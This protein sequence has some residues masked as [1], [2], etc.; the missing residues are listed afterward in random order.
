MPTAVLPEVESDTV[1]DKTR[2][3]LR[4]DEISEVQ[5]LLAEIA[6]RYETTEDPDFQEEAPL[7]AHELPVRIRREMLHFKLYEP[8]SALLVVGGYPIDEEKIGPTPA[9]W[10]LQELRRRVHEEEIF[11]VLLA[12]LLGECIG[13]STQQDGHLVHDIVPIAAHR[14][15]QLGSG[16]DTEL[17]WHIEDAFH[18]FRGDYL[19]LACLRNPDRVP[20]TF[21]TLEGIELPEEQMALLFEPHFTIRPD[22]SHKKKNKSESRQ[23]D[24]ELEH[25]YEEI[26]RMD[27]RPDKIAVLFGD[28]RAPYLRIDPYFMDPVE[29]PAAQAALDALIA[30]IGDKIED[31]VLQPG[32]F[33]FVDNFLGVHGRKPFKARFDGTDRWMK[34]V[35]IVRDLRKSRTARRSPQSRLVG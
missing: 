14:D 2:V 8:P 30:A 23:V 27:T 21:A 4:K 29:D 35:N 17:T 19:G 5:K 15:E 32:D 9:H 1:E 3:Q 7:L 22:E 26:E 11:Q 24:D 25:S 34:R 31:L 10:K 33:C 20:T 18:P 28:P 13:W 16:S 6:G 12:S